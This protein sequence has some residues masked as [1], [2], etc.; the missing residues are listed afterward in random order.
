V[1]SRLGAAGAALAL[2]VVSPALAQAPRTAPGE[3]PARH[4]ARPTA[5]AIT[6]QDAMSRLYV[7]A[8]DS[9]MGRDAGTRGNVMGTDYI[10]A[11]AR[12]IGLRPA[13]D[14]GTFFQTIPLV[15]R[16]MDPASTLTPRGGNAL[17]L[18]GDFVPLPYV[19]GF[20]NVSTTLSAQAAPVVYG[21]R[22]GDAA[23]ITPEQARGKFV[24]FS[25]V[26]APNGR[27]DFR[28][29]MQGPMERYS[30]AIG[31]AIAT[32]DASPPPFVSF[33][34][35]EQL[36]L[37]QDAPP[38]G[39]PPPVMLVTS[40]AAE[41]LLGAPLVS[42]QPGAAAAGG[43]TLTGGYRA[44]E[45]PTDF[46]ARNVVA[47]LPGTDPR[48]R[49]QYVAVGAHNDHVGIAP[50]AVDHDSV[51]V[52]NRLFRRGGAEGEAP[53]QLDPAQAARFRAALDSLRRVRPARMDSV[54]NGADDD[55]SGTV[56]VLEIAQSL[57]ARPPRRSVL[58]V[59]HTAE[60]KGLF[61]SEY[62]TSH[63]TV[64]RDSIIAQLNIDMIGRGGAGD[65]ENGGAKGERGREVPA[66]RGLAPP[67]HAA[68][69]PG[70]G[71]EPH[72]E[73]RLHLRLLD[74]RRRAPGEHLLPQRPLQLRAVGHPG[75]LLHHGWPP[76]L[77]HAHGRGA[78]RGLRQAGEREPLYRQRGRGRRQ[79]RRAPGGRQAQ[80][81]SAR[82]LQAVRDLTRR[83]R[84]TEIS[85]SL[86]LCVS[87]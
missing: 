56:A 22:W 81:R 45:R 87:V 80:A 59:W 85:S 46:P 51:L 82:H 77:P 12:R 41:Q 35:E 26:M 36:V 1:K 14:N 19:E 5:A 17:R 21:G 68:G 4:T 20:F 54:F 24:V 60:E 53:P 43:R 25:P 18:A 2:A 78:V 70:G 62:F 13:G 29:W 52:F 16:S 23:A 75:D 38:A 42:L 74:G 27:P 67:L 63:A 76:G 30:G 39:A 8:D 49:G 71:G 40:T 7:L 65:V 31:I 73:P 84:G 72:G 64:P 15:R 55:A 28:V 3:G 48:L 44:V 32:L 57:A 50:R 47:I 86:C 69:R 34:R 37:R 58:F 83:H 11:E 66:A 10:A 33:L 79:P 9:M 61:G 6:R